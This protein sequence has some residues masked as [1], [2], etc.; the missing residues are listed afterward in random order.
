MANLKKFTK[1]ACGHILQHFDRSAENTSNKNCLD[2]SRSHLNYNLA[3]D[4]QPLQQID[5]LRKRCGEV[6]C[7]NRAD[8]KVLAS[9]IITAPKDLPEAE[10]KEFFTECYEFLKN[11][12]GAQNVVS[13]WVHNDQ[14]TPHIHF[15]FIPVVKATKKYKSGEVRK[16]EKVCAVEV[17]TRKELQEFHPALHAHLTRAM[18]HEVSVVNG[19][20][21][22][23]G[24]K[25]IEEFK[26][27][28]NLRR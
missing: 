19:R 12:Y 18:G 6:Q 25:S 2:R 24:N 22:R 7:L 23:E 4:L 20:T 5:F 21:A 13:A 3:A 15:A 14:A 16:F 9:W 28:H 26:R 1:S 10:H 17:L 27:Q 11:R 8:V